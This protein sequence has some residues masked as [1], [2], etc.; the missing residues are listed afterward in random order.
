MYL[1]Y[2]GGG[3]GGGK[4]LWDAAREIVTS[5][6]QGKSTNM[7]SIIKFLCFFLAEI[8]PTE[9]NT[10]LFVGSRNGVK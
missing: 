7:F 9:S 10:V 5:R 1:L 6:E 4:S 2:S 8:V 3:G